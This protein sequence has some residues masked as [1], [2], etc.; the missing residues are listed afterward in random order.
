[1]NDSKVSQTK[2][3]LMFQSIFNPDESK[4]DITTFKGF[5][6]EIIIRMKKVDISGMGAQ[7]A[8]FFLLSFF[9]LLLV[10]VS[11]LP[12]LDINQEHVFRF[13]QT[14]VPAEVFMLTQGTIVEVLTTY[15]GGGVLSI[16]IL[17]T[18]W[19]ASRGMN[20][21]IK[22]LNEAYETEPKMGIIN[23]AWSLVFT[24]LLIL[25]LLLALIVP[26]FGQR[27]VYL[28]FDFLGVETSFVD[29]WNYVQ[30]ILPPL[31]IFIVLLLLYWVIPYTESRVHIVTVL[32]G[33]VFSTISWVVLIYG[34]SFYVNHFGNFTF[35]YGSIASVI[36]FMLWLYFTGMILIF[37]GILNAAMHKRHF[38]KIRKGNIS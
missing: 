26:I 28:L 9:P 6:Q 19:S 23:R 31:L 38:A 22:T 17:G 3:V 13:I 1:M 5:V 18:L 27:Y 2:W 37:G 11:T 32:P 14:I 15:N 33:T 35:T 7:L 12:F 21:I 16:G 36:I 29:F 34:F 24:V 10:V 25:I 8:Y 30:W 4:I 20:A